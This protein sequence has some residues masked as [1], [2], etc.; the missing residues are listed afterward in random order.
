MRRERP[1]K[2]ALHDVPRTSLSLFAAGLLGALGVPPLTA[3]GGTTVD[4]VDGTGGS[5]GTPRDAGA[6]GG[7][8]GRAE[9]GGADASLEGAGGSAPVGASGGFFSL[10]DAGHRPPTVAPIMTD[11]KNPKPSPG[12]GGEETGFVECEGGAKHRVRV[13]ECPSSVPRAGECGMDAGPSVNSCRI[14]AECTDAPRGFCRSSEYGC[15]CEYG[16][17]RDSDCGAGSICLCGDPIG[18]CAPAECTTDADCTGGMLCLSYDQAP[19]CEKMAVACQTPTDQCLADSDCAG[20]G[21]SCERQA[22]GQRTCVDQRCH[23]TP[24]RPFVVE[25]SPR[26]AGLASRGDWCSSL[27]PGLHALRPSERA[28]LAGHWTECALAEHASVASFARFALELLALGAPPELLLRAQQAMADEVRHA[29]DAFALASAYRGQSIGPGPL[30]VEGALTPPSLASVLRTA[31]LEGCIGETVA[32]V[33]AAEALAVVKD[34]AVRAAL[35]RVAPDEAAHAE[36]AFRFVKWAL[37]QAGPDLRDELV[38]EA[39]RIVDGAG[40]AAR[41]DD[42]SNMRPALTSHGALGGRFRQELRRRV[43]DEVVAPCLR[44]IAASPVRASRRAVG[45]SG[46][47]QSSRSRTSVAMSASPSTGMVRRDPR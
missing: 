33:E 16:C 38:A 37:D 4:R 23:E 7:N 34:D 22:T 10:G 31:L 26:V 20:F 8:G 43:I 28:E 24:G 40:R 32:A 47:A 35:S 36:L 30:D 18:K 2:A 46:G 14:D 19:G 39:M 13:V 44:A 12:P 5:G 17:V 21:V 25:G 41:V 1:S 29:R 11:C 42:T 27:A 45:A 9:S 3:C 15:Y 6:G